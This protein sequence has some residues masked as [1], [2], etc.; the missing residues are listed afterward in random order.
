MV[1]LTVKAIKKSEKLKLCLLLC[2]NALD[3]CKLLEQQGMV[4]GNRN[5]GGI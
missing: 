1:L 5:F 3:C 4:V 2:Y